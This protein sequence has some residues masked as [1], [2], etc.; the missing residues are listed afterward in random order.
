[1]LIAALLLLGLAFTGAWIVAAVQPEGEPGSIIPWFL[2]AA[3]AIVLLGLVGIV[4]R[5]RRRS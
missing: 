3:A 1:M 5:A 2:G 4:V